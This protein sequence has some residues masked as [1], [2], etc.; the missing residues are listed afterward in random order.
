MK[1]AILSVSYGSGDKAQLENTVERLESLYRRTFPDCEVFRAFTS[2]HVIASLQKAGIRVDTVSEALDRLR[3]AGYDAVYIQPTHIISGGE[4][5]SIL[6]CAR[7]RSGDFRVLR[8]GKPLLDSEEDRAYICHFFEKELAKANR[9]LVLM[10]HGSAHPDNIQYARLQETAVRLGYRDLFIMT[11]EA[12]PSVQDILPLMR[13]AGFS[14]VLLTPLLF[15]AAG[16]A[17]RDMA[18][19]EPGSVASTLRANGFAVEC[20][21]KGLGEYD[22]FAALYAGHLHRTMEEAQ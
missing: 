6:D 3:D 22:A 15:G 10:G 11:L 21:V 8:V 18:G 17:R 16:H 20:L 13:A 9:A 7:A 4:Y 12:S 1:K 14:G 5:D 19:D 2:K